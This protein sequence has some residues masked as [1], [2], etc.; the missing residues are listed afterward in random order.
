MRDITAIIFSRQTRQGDLEGN[1]RY[2]QEV[3]LNR[4][5]WA[6]LKYAHR[7]LGAADARPWGTQLSALARRESAS[8]GLRCSQEE[9]RPV[10]ISPWPTKWWVHSRLGHSRPSCD[11][12]KFPTETDCASQQGRER[13]RK[14][15]NS[16]RV[17]LEAGTGAPHRGETD[18]VGPA[19]KDEAVP[20]RDRALAEVSPLPRRRP[21]RTG[22]TRTRRE[23]RLYAPGGRLAEGEETGES[24]FGD[25]PLRLV[26]LAESPL[27]V[28]TRDSSGVG[29][30]LAYH[31][32]EQGD[33]QGGS[34]SR[35]LARRAWVHERGGGGR[36]CMEEE[37]TLLLE[38]DNDFFSFFGENDVIA[39]QG[40]TEARPR[41]QEFESDWPPSPQP[42][43]GS[44]Q[45]WEGA[46]D[47]AEKG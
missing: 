30:C 32:S 46:G 31:S 6:C 34:G 12:E 43:S 40:K 38:E 45:P 29:D 23:E 3:K 21:E 24:S 20:G 25:R 5:A 44:T 2:R 7:R 14:V 22:A 11:D 9:Q 35:C 19:D 8:R 18:A 33:F 39:F 16:G 47:A 27:A 28:P 42:Q 1:P 41:E 10:A 17:A 15:E 37:P 4:G 13:S 36:D 26:D